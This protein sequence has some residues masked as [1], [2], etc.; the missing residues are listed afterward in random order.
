MKVKRLSEMNLPNYLIESSGV[1]RPWGVLH[2]DAIRGV[3][4]ISAHERAMVRMANGIADYVNAMY[5]DM[6]AGDVVAIE[7]G[8]GPMLSSWQW[9]LN[10]PTGRLDSGACE[11]WVQYI[12][13]VIGYDLDMR[14]MRKD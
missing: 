8:I 7:S 9:L 6:P 12:A 5:E 4:A 3:R 2:H 14:E 13:Q 11:S 1:A 10:H